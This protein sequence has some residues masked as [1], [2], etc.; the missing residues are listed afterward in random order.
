M[1]IVNLEPSEA[2][3]L[4]MELSEHATEKWLKE[5]GEE[6]DGHLSRHHHDDEN[7]PARAKPTLAIW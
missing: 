2:V 3:V 1:M 7:P 5:P 6:A 4:K